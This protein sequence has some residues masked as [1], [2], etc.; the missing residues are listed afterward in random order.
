MPTAVEPFSMRASSIGLGVRAG[1]DQ[2]TSLSGFSAGIEFGKQY[3][4][5]PGLSVG[6]RT[7]AMLSLRF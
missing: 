6:Y 2:L 5:F 1:L 4:D 3:S 7:T